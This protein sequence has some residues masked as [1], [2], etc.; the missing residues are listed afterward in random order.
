MDDINVVSK[1]K[2][3][4]GAHIWAFGVLGGRGSYDL[5]VECPSS[6]DMKGHNRNSQCGSG[7]ECEEAL[8][9]SISDEEP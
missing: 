5:N 9:A 6:V 3:E 1:C 4:I 2:A 8:S 7:R